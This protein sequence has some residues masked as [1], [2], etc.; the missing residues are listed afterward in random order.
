MTLDE[1]LTSLERGGLDTPDTSRNRTGVSV[2]AVQTDTCTP[3]TLDTP[4]NDN[5]KNDNGKAVN[6]AQEAF[7]WWRL[8][9]ADHHSKEACYYPAATRDHVLAGEPQAIAAEA[10]EPVL[11]KPDQPLSE[12]DEAVIRSLLADI[13]EEDEGIALALERC[14]TDQ[15]AREGFL[16]LAKQWQGGSRVE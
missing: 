3:D 13:G 15:G 1:L 6:L 10:F 12:K 7:C 14:R 11:R 2:K 8:H 9:Y 5:E 4:Q 16:R